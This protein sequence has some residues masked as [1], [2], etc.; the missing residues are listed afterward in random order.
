M[1]GYVLGW[2]LG[3]AHVKAALVDKDGIVLEVRQVSC[4]LWKGIDN[5]GKAIQTILDQIN[6]LPQSHVITMTGE[7]VDIF[8]DRSEGVL[9]IAD[10]VSQLLEGKIRF[11]AGLEGLVAIADVPYKTKSIASAN[12]LASASYLAKKISHGLF[13]DIGS[14]TSD[15]ILIEN[16]QTKVMGFSDAER[17]ETEE[18]IYTGVVRTPLM[19]FGG[20]VPFLGKWTNIVSE[21]FATTADIYRLTGELDASYDMC[22][23]ADGTNKS[24]ESSARRLARMIGHDFEDVPMEKWKD[25]ARYF[26]GIQFEQLRRTSL[27]HLS[28]TSS[29]EPIPLIGAGVGAFVVESL[30][31]Q[32][33]L[34][35]MNVSNL[36]K[37]DDKRLSSWS[38]ACFPAYALAS[39]VIDN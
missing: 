37:S 7:L 38:S 17:L 15:F 13:I 6:C 10:M 28:R 4:P 20:K 16:S 39:L 33:G 34:P 14:T 29:R 35:Y 30:A 25:L 23:T 26:R 31:K 12:W 8:N 5:L 3:G 2:D 19:T 21:Y 9:M 11:Y 1:L 18:L 32:I 24:S 36:V 27:L 22:E